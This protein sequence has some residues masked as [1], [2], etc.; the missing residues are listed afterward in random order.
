[1]SNDAK[2][3]IWSNEHVAW[4][5]SDRCGYTKHFDAAG[6]YSRAEAISICASARDGW[7][8]CVI[9]SE[10]PVLEADVLECIELDRARVI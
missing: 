8:S 6:R 9:P 1:M 4:L 2:Y 3:L 7:C 10:I 5:R